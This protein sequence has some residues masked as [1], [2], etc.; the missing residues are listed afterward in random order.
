MPGTHVP[1]RNFCSLS[2]EGPKAQRRIT[3]RSF[4]AD[5]RELWTQRIEVQALKT[6]VR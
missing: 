2:V 3:L 6:P 5:G 1:Q 4:D